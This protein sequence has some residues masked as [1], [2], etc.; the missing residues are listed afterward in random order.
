[1]HDEPS[2][3]SNVKDLNE[4]AIAYFEERLFAMSGDL[5]AVEYAYREGKLTRIEF[6][7]IH[8]SLMQARG[9]VQAALDEIASVEDLSRHS[10]IPSSR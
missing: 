4:M 1:M 8:R 6:L 10:A 2:Q 3:P 9:D 7:G 5:Y